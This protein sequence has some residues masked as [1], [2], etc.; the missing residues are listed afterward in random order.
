[1]VAGTVQS[2]TPVPPKSGFETRAF[3]PTENGREIVSV[4]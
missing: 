3:K 2:E 4:R 1:M